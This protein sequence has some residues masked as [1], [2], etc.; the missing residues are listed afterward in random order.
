MT[1][2]EKMF[3][4]ERFGNVKGTN[5]ELEEYKNFSDDLREVYRRGYKRNP[6]WSHEQTMLYVARIAADWKQWMRHNSM[7]GVGFDIANSFRLNEKQKKE[8][9]SACENYFYNDV[10]F[11]EYHK[12]LL[13]RVRKEY[14]IVLTGL[15]EMAKPK[16]PLDVLLGL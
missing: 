8:L 14:H 6:E 9:I 7:R 16:G 3:I 11:N 12:S 2:E 4:A 13:Y 5:K 1:D 10:P 15:S